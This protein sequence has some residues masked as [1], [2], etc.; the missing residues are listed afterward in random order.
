MGMGTGREG[1]GGREGGGN[2]GGRDGEGKS[3][4]ERKEGGR[5][6]GRVERRGDGRGG[7]W[8]GWAWGEGAQLFVSVDF[9]VQV[10][11][12]PAGSVIVR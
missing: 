5:E 10:S 7:K 2:E 1:M 3:V 4:V 9:L 6:G 12:S 11:K 8:E